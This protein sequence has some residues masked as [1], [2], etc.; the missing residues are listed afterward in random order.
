MTSA[1]LAGWVTRFCLV[2]V[3]I[4]EDAE[5]HLPTAGDLD[6]SCKDTQTTF[7]VPAGGQPL[8]SRDPELVRPGKATLDGSRCLCSIQ[9]SGSL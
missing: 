4:P 7:H 3:T 6:L 5:L 8:G 1:K 9:E 2:F